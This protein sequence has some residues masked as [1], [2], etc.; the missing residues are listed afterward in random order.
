MKPKEYIESFQIPIKKVKLIIKT[1]K[2]NKSLLMFTVTS[3]GSLVVD[4]SPYFTP[5]N[6]RWGSY[7][8]PAGRIDKDTVS[9]LP[10]TIHLD[11]NNGPKFTYHRSGWVTVGK[12]GHHESS[13]IQANPLAQA[14]GHIFTLQMKGFDKL[15]DADTTKRKYVYLGP[16]MPN[17][18]NTLK[19]VASIGNLEDFVTDKADPHYPKGNSNVRYVKIIGTEKIEVAL[20]KIILGT[21]EERWLMLEFWPNYPYNINTIEPSLSLLTGWMQEDAMDKT[22][23]FKCLGILAG[24]P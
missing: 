20:F 19:V 11:Q 23:S 22:K 10:G 14:S 21:G 17:L 2:L 4:P 16:L 15:K 24:F 8:I 12:T 6:W 13:R 5:G 9:M 1:D 7:E 18:L 3:D